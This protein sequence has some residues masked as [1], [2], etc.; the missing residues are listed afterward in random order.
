MI[1][2]NPA[3]LRIVNRIVR[4]LCFGD[5]LQRHADIGSVVLHIDIRFIS[6]DIGYAHALSAD[7]PGAF[8]LVGSERAAPQE[9]FRESH[10]MPHPCTESALR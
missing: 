9:S 3:A 1:E 6:S 10:L 4:R 2:I 8:A 5:S 7:I